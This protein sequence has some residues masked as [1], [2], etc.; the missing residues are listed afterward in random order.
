MLNSFEASGL[1]VLG[2]EGTLTLG[3]EFVGKR[4]SVCQAEPGVW[5]ITLVPED[6][7]WLHQPAAMAAL[8]KAIEWAADHPVGGVRDS[9]KK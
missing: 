9:Q 4:V 6:E 3:K 2:D 1:Q 5:R 7:L 8:A